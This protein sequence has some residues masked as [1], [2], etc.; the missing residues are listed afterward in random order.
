MY[1]ILFINKYLKNYYIFYKIQNIIYY[2]IDL[3]FNSINEYNIYSY[4]GKSI[5]KTINI[6]PIKNKRYIS[7][8][9]LPIKIYNNT[10]NING[11]KYNYLLIILNRKAKIINKYFRN[12]YIRKLNKLTKIY[13]K[14]HFIQIYNN[15]NSLCLDVIEK[16][17]NHKK[18]TT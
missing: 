4:T 9:L 15:N 2:I 12:Y 8:R 13:K 7:S 17:L 16:I 5:N 14:L 11:I 6:L 1:F 3:I 18:V 10:K